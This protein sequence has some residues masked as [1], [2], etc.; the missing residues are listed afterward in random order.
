LPLF[1][2]FLPDDLAA[3]FE[4]ARLFSMFLRAKMVWNYG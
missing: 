3:P 1:R 2:D 4:K